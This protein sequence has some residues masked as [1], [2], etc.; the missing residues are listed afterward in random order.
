[1]NFAKVWTRLKP[2]FFLPCLSCSSHVIRVLWCQRVCSNK[3]NMLEI[4]S[5]SVFASECVLLWATGHHSFCAQ[6]Y[7]GPCSLA[8][9]CCSCS[10]V[11][12]RIYL[13]L[14]TN[15]RDLN[16]RIYISSLRH[17]MHSQSFLFFWLGLS[18]MWNIEIRNICQ[19][20]NYWF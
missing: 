4:N 8:F 19:Y 7:V 14:Q 5:H 16:M 3:T 1:M 20:T 17:I 6:E 13:S 10:S 15:K 11:S 2:S 9:V 18:N 12:P